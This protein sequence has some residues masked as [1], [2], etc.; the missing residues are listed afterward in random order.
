MHA[1]VHCTVWL[2]LLRCDGDFF[3]SLRLPAVKVMEGVRVG[4][5]TGKSAWYLGKAGRQASQVAETNISM[6]RGFLALKA[7]S[8]RHTSEQSVLVESCSSFRPMDCPGQRVLR[9]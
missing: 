7:V 9:P 8:S 4:F 6:T 5:E 3:F 1:C 2:L